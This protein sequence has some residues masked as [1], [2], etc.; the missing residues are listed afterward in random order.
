MWVRFTQV[1]WLLG[2]VIGIS[3]R[4]PD[5]HGFIGDQNFTVEDF[6]VQNRDRCPSSHPSLPSTRNNQS[7]GEALSPEISFAAHG[8]PRGWS[9]QKRQ[10]CKA[11]KT[12]WRELLRKTQSVKCA[13]DQLLEK[14]N[15]GDE[16]RGSTKR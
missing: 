14:R 15:A 13:R 16:H 10:G 11:K 1:R 2:L 7:S 9:F 4:P 6:I 5:S 12:R 3:D 8:F